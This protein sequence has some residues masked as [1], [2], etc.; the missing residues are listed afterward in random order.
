MKFSL[1]ASLAN[2]DG[3]HPVLPCISL[4]LRLRR[5][6]VIWGWLYLEASILRNGR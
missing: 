1:K 5:V 3:W 2:E 6:I 4:A